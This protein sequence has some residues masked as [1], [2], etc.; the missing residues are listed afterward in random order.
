MSF[1][2][3][4]VRWGLGLGLCWGIQACSSAPASE[5]ASASS[6]GMAGGSVVAASALAERV[7]PA[8]GA[9]QRIATPLGRLAVWELGPVAAPVTV[10]LWP[11]IF[12][13]HIVHEPLARALSARHRVILLDGPGH[14]LSE[15]PRDATY[16]MLACAEALNAV[17]QAK[18]VKRAVVGGTSWGGL[19][20]AE[21]ALRYPDQ[22]QALVMMNTPFLVP[23]EG[24]GWSESLITW[25]SRH[26]LSTGLFTS[27]VARSFFAPT[28][29][30]RDSAYMA[31]FHQ[32]LHASD[33]HA[34][35]TAIR[36]VLIERESLG[37][38]LPSLAAP[39]LVI[40]GEQDD[41]YPLAQQRDAV[42][43]MQRG[44]I[45]VVNS[46]H[47]SVKDAPNEV[48]ALV[49]TFLGTVAEAR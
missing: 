9:P 28:T 12:T 7:S 11:S 1:L 30:E 44:R 32:S 15:G 35:S 43:R 27:G 34:L 18:G 10:V 2:Q 26:L 25:G 38:R 37:P 19:V 33:P 5:S 39:A 42:S 3:S 40:A 17:L 21:Y 4:V 8:L 13:D 23:P 36:S 46:K 16:T 41:M 14:G 20:A 48:L 31:H 29:R 47:I 49:S 45:E 6:R 24:P 22:T